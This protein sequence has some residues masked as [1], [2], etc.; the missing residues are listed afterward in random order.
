MPNQF[1]IYTSEDPQGP[2]YITGQPGSLVRV[3]DAVL[4]NGYGT[5]S[6]YKPSAGWTKPAPNSGSVYAAYQLPSGSRMCMFVNDNSPTVRTNLEAIILGWNY[7]TSSGTDP[8]ASTPSAHIGASGS[9]GVFPTYQQAVSTAGGSYQGVIVRKS[10]SSDT[11]SRPWVIAADAY[12]MYMWI[13]HGAFANQYGFTSFGD[14][15][16]I[17]GSSD[18]WNCHIN[19]AYQYDSHLN[20]YADCI[21]SNPPRSSGY[22]NYHPLSNYTYGFY[23]ANTA[24]GAGGPIMACRMGDAGMSGDNYYQNAPHFGQ[25]SPDPVN[26][27]F[28]VHPLYAVEPACASIRGKFRGLYYP[29]HS[30]LSIPN[31]FTFQGTGEYAGKTFMILSWGYRG[32]FWALETSNTLEVSNP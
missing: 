15:F 18:R 7:M 12:T 13:S 16:S 19:G 6:Y 22:Y 2:G 31:G 28:F 8:G 17:R 23:L 3:L 20:T 32:G 1:R 4:V 21:A 14:I 24:T 30:Y 11:V 27:N 26:L 5:G 9:S 10:N 29:I 25:M